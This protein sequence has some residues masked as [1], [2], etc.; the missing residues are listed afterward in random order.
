MDFLVSIII[1]LLLRWSFHFECE[2]KIII[3]ILIIYFIIDLK[4]L[5]IFKQNMNYYISSAS[6]FGN[7]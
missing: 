2:T 6:I 3:I 7:F 5:I 1:I 4:Y